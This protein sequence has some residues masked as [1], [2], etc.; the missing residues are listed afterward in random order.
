MSQAVASDR[1]ALRPILLLTGT[2]LGWGLAWPMIKIGLNEIPPWTY[3]GLM[4]PVAGVV[5]F[6]V[7]RAMGERFALPTGQWGLLLASSLL[8]ITCWTLFS[9]L[10]LRLM[11]SGHASILAYTMP[12]WAVILSMLL[13]GER[14]TLRRIVGLVLGLAGLFV[15]L[16]GEF[17]VLAESP[18]GTLLMLISAITWGAG[19]VLHKRVVWTLPA[20]MTIAW[21]IFLGG[22]PITAVAL[23]TEL[24][25]L[26]PISWEAAWS[27]LFVLLIS[28]VAC[29]FAWFSVVK[30]VPVIV[31]SVSIMGVPVVA[32]IS[33]AILL[34]EHLDLQE[35]AALGLVL[36]AIALVVVPRRR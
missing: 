15:L 5:M 18:A 4:L 34:S 23:V 35:I 16:Q 11:G 13:I 2:I 28:V 30:M 8:N 9:T 21:M 26:R 12:L 3:R 25:E 17:G 29:W 20:A 14:P 6:A 10:G 24:D 36:S 1:L 33:G 19:T 27:T 31:S 22:L 7:A 32:V